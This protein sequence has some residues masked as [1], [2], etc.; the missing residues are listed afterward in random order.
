MALLKANTGIG[1]TNPTSSLH[2]IGDGLIT[3]VVTATTFN[4]NIN[5]G[6]A[7]LT[8]IN[9]SGVST[10]GYVNAQSVNSSGIVTGSTFRPSSGYIQSPNGTNAFYIYDGT[11]NVAFQGTIG[12]SQVNNGQGYRVIGFAGTDNASFENHLYVAGVTTSAGGFVGNLTGA[13]ST[14]SFATTAFTLNG[15]TEGNLSVGFARSA[16]V[17]TSVIGG[18]A[19]VTSLN[20]SG[21]ST[22]ATALVNQLYVSGISTFNNNVNISQLSVSGS[23]SFTGAI[24]GTISTATKL[25]NARTFEITGDVVASPISFDGTG[26]VSLAATIQPNSV[27]LGN[28]TT[29]DY[30]QT[31]TGTSNQITVTGGTGEGSTPTL[32][33]PNQFTVPQ[34][35]TVLRDV[36]IDR[37]LNVNGNITIGGTSA[38]IF[39]TT[40]KISD[41]DIVLGFRTDAFGNDISNDN[42][43]NHGGVAL[44]STEGTPLVNLFIAGIETNPATYKKIMWF[45]SGT[46]TGLNTDAWLSNY[47]VGIGSTQFPVGTRLA[48]G[49]VQFTENDLAVVRNINASGVSTL[50]VTTFTGAVSFGTSA[51]FG[52]NDSLY[53]GDSNDLQIYHNSSNNNSIIEE[54]GSGNLILRGGNVVIQSNALETCASFIT[55]GAVELYHDNSKKFETTGYGATVF[56][57]LQAQG[58]QVSG[59]STFNNTLNVVPTSTG[60]AGLFS[61]TTSADMVRITQTGS[62]NALLVEDETNP[63]TTPFVVSASGSVGIGTTNPEEELHVSV[64]QN[65]GTVIRVE[66]NFIGNS[67]NAS[68]RVSSA[69]TTVILSVH[70]PSRTGT[71]YGITQGGYGELSLNGGNGLL[72]GTQNASPLILGTNDTEALRIDSSQRVGIGTT[73]PT[74]KLHVLGNTLVTGVST[75]LSNSSTEAFR[76]TQLGTGNALVVEDETNPDSTPFVVTGI[77]SVGIGTTNPVAPI[78]IS[79]TNNSATN[80][81]NADAGLL[82][83][84][85]ASN[86]S[87]LKLE[88]NA[89]I[90][91]GGGSGTLIIADRQNERIRINSSGLVGIGTTNPTSTLTVQ[92]NAYITG[93]TTSTDFD[94][95]SDINLKTNIN[96]I[97]DPLEKVMQIRGVTFNWKEGN[98][99]SA[100][101]IAQ[102]IEKVL[103]ELVHGGETKT[104]NYNGLIGL[105]IECVK[106]QQKEIE[107]LKKKVN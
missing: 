105:L 4:G 65:S 56:G 16:G 101:V 22:L 37:N 58:L 96:Q 104:V 33:I 72:V 57:T 44:A 82:I 2:V 36:Q 13:A 41:P 20:V 3:G 11:G 78:H 45:K 5:S 86:G 85:L 59:V 7:S 107:E 32:S 79:Y 51:Y 102:E 60:I 91:Y 70:N 74:S 34:D 69:S 76:I 99:N 31:V 64:D 24:T 62:G 66:N 92:G 55:N 61:G 25:Q 49:S 46:F 88:G 94:S 38:T 9:S 6:I 54:S 80:Y 67:A 21:V 17:S 98:R 30:V 97:A 68:V 89:N 40:L 81:L 18:I 8:N 19:S 15:V 47:A 87:T 52:D 106:K 39:S 12:A 103:P 29:G 23:S 77:G 26:N 14:A 75:I 84:N 48:A 42:T 90:I 10:L 95:L 27:A 71:K 50:G 53:F 93:V 100:G 83:R 1:T 28:D 63:D 73:N 43:A 35:L